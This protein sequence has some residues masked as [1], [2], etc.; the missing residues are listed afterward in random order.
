MT[1]NAQIAFARG[2]PYENGET[3]KERREAERAPEWSA[4]R[5]ANEALNARDKAQRGNFCALG[6]NLRVPRV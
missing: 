2:S 6:G 1:E 3:V 5:A 4:A